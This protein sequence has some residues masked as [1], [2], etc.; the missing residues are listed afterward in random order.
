[1]ASRRGLDRRTFLRGAGGAALFGAIGAGRGVASD[2]ALLDL[3]QE[4]QSF[5]FD[6]V[7]DRFGTNA[8]KW[9]GAVDDMGTAI[10]AGMGV[11]DMDFR[12][13]PC[14]TRALE[15]R[16]AHEN[17]GY[18]RT[19]ASYYE[20]I[21][22]WNRRHYG[23]QID[24]DGIELTT[25]VHAGLIA[26]L[27]ALAPPGSRVLM[28][29]PIYSGF[30]SD[31]RFTRTI[32]EDSPMTLVNGRYE[33][34]FDDFER[35]A[36]RS[37]VMILCN[38][39]NPTGNVWSPEELTRIGEICLRHRV[40]V[41]ADEIHCDFVRE[42]ARYT[43]FASLPDR[44]IVDN[45]LTFKAATKTFSLSAMRTGWYFSTNPDLLERVRS[46]TRADLTT[47]GVIAT[48]AA[49]V[50]GDGWLA[51]LNPY[52]DGNL[53]FVE[54]FVR[55]E[56]PLVD[57]RLEEGTYL[58]W[59]DVGPALEATGVGR[60]AADAIGSGASTTPERMLQRWLAEHARVLLNPGSSFG[61]GGAGRM[62]LNAATSRGVLGRGLE[63]MAEALASV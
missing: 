57:Y 62:R 32:P 10:E 16:C 2:A 14:V 6:R 35:R 1:M 56:M 53:R 42:G 11:A 43:P 8:S 22:D 15:E 36:R 7:L 37:N 5:D 54:R 20:A 28:T 23:L 4:Q 51:Q 29:S 25:G 3:T 13:A 61:T 46:F 52:L 30:Y 55:E 58:A 59:L 34:D 60:A 27:H 45:S 48:E 63:N 31:I 19:P 40:V 9:D 47:L 18:T 26:A 21:V 41:L 44:D 17:W 38:P 12:V 50:E 33:V 39:Q 49:L 24:P